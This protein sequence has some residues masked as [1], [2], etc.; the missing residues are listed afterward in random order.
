MS[1]SPN[2]ISP[3][4]TPKKNPWGS[5]SRSTAATCSLQEVMSE[6]LASELQEKEYVVVSPSQAEAA[7]P[8]VPDEWIDAHKEL[9]EAAAAAAAAAAD[10]TNTPTTTDNDLILAQLL[11]LEFD[12]EYDASLARYEEH[13]NQNRSVKLSYDNFKTVHPQTSADEQTALRRLEEDDLHSDEEE[14]R[15]A[16]R[17]AASKFNKSGVR[18]KGA[19][20]VTKHDALLNG[21]NNASKVISQFPPEFETG[22]YTRGSF[23]MRLPNHVY[24]AL[25][26]HSVK[27]ESRMNRLH[28]K[29]DQSTNVMSL[30]PKTKL[31]LYKL[32]NADVLA[33]VGGVISTGKE[34]TILYAQGGHSKEVLVP[35]ECVAKVYK[36]TLNEFKTRAQYIADDYRFKD[37]YKHLNPRKIVKLWAEKEMHNLMKMRRF[38]GDEVPCPDV[39]ALKKHVLLMSFI[40][41][42][43]KPAPKLKDLHF[44]DEAEMRSA[45]EQCVHLIET[46]YKKCNMVHADFNQF[47]L[48]WH[49]KKVWVIDVSQSVEPIHP[50]G[51]EF[52][53]RDCST[54]SRFFE[55]RKLDGVMSAEALFNKITGFDFSGQG[56]EFL[57]QVSKFGKSKLTELTL[58]TDKSVVDDHHFDYHFKRAA[59]GSEEQDDQESSSEDEEDHQEWA[60]QPFFFFKLPLT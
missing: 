6:Q 4:T 58:R 5:A 39:I 50:K 32:V 12:R 36:T 15:E 33:G 34:A 14:A 41:S 31:L 26:I 54:I 48:L 22:D 13:V 16:A 28:D 40:G 29:S 55:S 21:R 37:R 49:E 3:S 17:I 10:A 53:L 56:A 47:N 46:L 59:D 38:G 23:D 45:Y 35:K 2:V 44:A 11:Q 42:D 9:K 1:A 57:T 25:K 27:V 19:Q 43:G 8:P 51:L 20:M 18:G 30:D 24:N 60:R 52:L 7:I